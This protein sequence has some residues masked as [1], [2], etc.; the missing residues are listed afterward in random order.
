MI[1]KILSAAII[2]FCF[3]STLA[4]YGCTG[5]P[6]NVVAKY[7]DS[8]K[9]GDFEKADE[10]LSKESKAL[11]YFDGFLADMKIDADDKESKNAIKILFKKVDVEIVSSTI[12]ENTAVV[13]TKIMVPDIA[14]MFL[15]LLPEI[16]KISLLGGDNRAQEYK[17]ML[18]DYIN[19]HNVD[20][21]QIEKEIE[22]VK[23]DG[24]WKINFNLFDLIDIQGLPEF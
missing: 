3:F 14:G 19:N 16:I 10:Y 15:S 8:I 20:T 13:E 7:F 11:R 2:L 4:L 21:K 1:K 22:L 23:E 12:D 5:K 18:V 24:V 17:D 6:E 9:K